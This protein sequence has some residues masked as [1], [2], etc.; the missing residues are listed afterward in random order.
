MP[1]DERPDLAALAAL[2]D[3]L[4]NLESELAGWRRRA[5][6]GEARAADLLRML[7]AGDDAPSRSKQ[8]EET[9]RELQQRLEAA[10]GRVHDLLSRLA[11]LEQ[12]SGTNGGSGGAA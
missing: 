8:L 5:L 12:Q 10:K 4:K 2:E 6:A 11:F 7:E 1:A 9:G 3:V